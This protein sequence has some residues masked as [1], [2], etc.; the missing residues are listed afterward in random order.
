MHWGA[1]LRIEGEVIVGLGGRLAVK[2]STWGCPQDPTLV[3]AVVDT[4]PPTQ[5]GLSGSPL[6]QKLALHTH[7]WQLR[8]HQAGRE[9]PVE[10]DREPAP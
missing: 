8:F 4:A 5:V 6:P 7:R 1:G 2:E 3:P 10:V 9:L